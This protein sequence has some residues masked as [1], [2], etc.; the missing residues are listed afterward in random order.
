MLDCDWSSDVCSSDLTEYKKAA[1]LRHF[2]RATV[3]TRDGVL[4]ATP[5]PNQS[6]GA[7]SSVVGATH[8]ISVGPDVTELAA[9]SE[10]SLLQTDWAS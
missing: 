5:L 9:G 4:V 6:S 10:V 7:Y 2:L 8:L 1:G 3:E